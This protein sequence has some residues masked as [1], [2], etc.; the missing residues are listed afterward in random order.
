MTAVLD[1]LLITSWVVFSLAV[2]LLLAFVHAC[3][4]EQER[5]ALVVALLA[6]LPVLGLFLCPLLLAFPARSIVLAVILAGGAVFLLLLWLPMG[7]RQPLRIVADIEPVD[8]RDAV[9]HRFY[10]LQP[11]SEDYQN[12]YRAH[13][14]QQKPDEKIRAL[15]ALE[16]PGSKT[17]HPL[18]SAYQAACSHVLASCTQ[19]LDQ[20][21]QPLGGRP[22]EASSAE[23]TRR[24]K[25]F[26]GYLGARLIGCTRLNPA[27]VYTH[28]ARGAG[29]WGSPI[30]LGHAN[31][32]AIGVA[33]SHQMVRQAPD[34]P[35]TT[36]TTLQYFEAGKIAMILAE[37]IRL[38]GYPARA[39]V[40]G[41]YQLMCVPVAADAGLGELGRLGLL[42]TPQFGPRVRL[43]VVS[44]DLPLDADSPIDF[45]VQSF[46][47]ICKKCAYNC[48]S[49]SIARK[50]KGVF[51]GVE[52]WQSQQDSC[53]R[54]WRQAGSDCAVCVKV[55]PY[56]HPATRLH[57]L[58]RY[59]VS[60][61]HLAR[62]LMLRADDFFY[63]RRPPKVPPPPPSW[64][65]RTG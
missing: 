65:D 4:K 6:G 34:S 25:G 2:L 47:A 3:I 63:G 38:L 43:A 35:T 1:W 8:E 27:Y 37:Y 10:R 52:K 53:Y 44:T 40:D 13:P 55:C 49:G 29:R 21:P 28:R 62:K 12:Y 64:H 54:Y 46:C 30:E 58:A 31:A 18:T 14:Q 61:N 50:D 36:E 16:A 41:N 26:A 17:H 56:S 60:R 51:A 19:Q 24:V 11:G 23:F 5:R 7:A 48:P 57:N 45:G 15:P 42:V 33:M 22:V 32:I 59:L 20:D 39:H 9:F